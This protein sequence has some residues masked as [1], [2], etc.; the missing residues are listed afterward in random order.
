[1]LHFRKSLWAE[2]SM[3]TIVLEADEESDE[4][5]HRVDLEVDTGKDRVESKMRPNWFPPH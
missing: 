4:E 1:M 5:P 2:T 3:N